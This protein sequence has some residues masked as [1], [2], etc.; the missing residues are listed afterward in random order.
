MLANIF[1]TNKFKVFNFKENAYGWNK[2]DKSSDGSYE[3]Q[4]AATGR[5]DGV[6]RQDNEQ[7]H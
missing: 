3:L 5:H 2:K 1:L 4:S 7:V 6:K